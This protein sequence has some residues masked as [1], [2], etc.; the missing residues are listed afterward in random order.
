MRAAQSIHVRA[1]EVTRRPPISATCSSGK[2]RRR[3]RTPLLRDALDRTARRR[4]PVRGR[5]RATAGVAAPPTGCGQIGQTTASSAPAATAADSATPASPQRAAS[6][7]RTP[8]DG[9]TKVR[10]RRGFVRQASA[11]AAVTSEDVWA[12]RAAHRMSASAAAG[13]P[14]ARGKESAVWTA[15]DGARPVD[16]SSAQALR[17]RQRVRGRNVCTLGERGLGALL[18]DG[19]AAVDDD[20]LPGHVGG[21]GRAQPR[22]RTGHLHRGGAAPHRHAPALRAPRARSATP[23][24]SSRAR[25]RSPSRPLRRS[26]RR[27][28]GPVPPW[29]PSPRRRRARPAWPSPARSR[30]P[31]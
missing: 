5:M 27:W 8:R 25:P 18:G 11:P 16:T 17:H 14:H 3:P 4:T 13:P 20:A 31:R 1:G 23:S 30:W 28:T 15:R 24:R 22:H 7:T 21:A 19:V 2:R 10:S 12:S 29:L 9:A 26:R 6:T